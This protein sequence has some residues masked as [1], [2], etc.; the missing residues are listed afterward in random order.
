MCCGGWSLAEDPGPL[1]GR[2]LRF[3]F[4]F[5]GVIVFGLAVAWAVRS[6][7]VETAQV[8]RP[9][10]HFTVDLLDGGTWS[11]ADHFGPTAG[12][13]VLNLW[14]SWCIPCRTEMPDLDEFARAHPEVTV[15]GV[16]VNDTLENATR[17]SGEVGVAYPL[18][19]GN[20]AFESSY[21]WLGLPVTWVIDGSG[22]VTA[23][24]NGIITVEGLERL[25]SR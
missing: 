24:H 19:F 16:A 25:T 23:L 20:P 21:P 9:A 8:G 4:V 5:L 12:P 11:L 15:I 14:A 17:F 7:P 2:P 22:T 6:Q 1:E 3:T 18:G 13:V 10:P